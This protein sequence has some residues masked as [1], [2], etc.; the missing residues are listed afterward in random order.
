MV[1]VLPAAGLD[2]AR[3]WPSREATMLPPPARVQRT[4]PV[5]SLT[6]Q[7]CTVFPALPDCTATA[8]SFSM[9]QAATPTEVC[10]E[11]RPTWTT[12]RGACPT[13]ATCSVAGSPPARGSRDLATMLQE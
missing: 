10:S 3:Y 11:A 6:T 8:R 2:S 12:F 4:R 5:E 13:A 9:E 1:V 7:H